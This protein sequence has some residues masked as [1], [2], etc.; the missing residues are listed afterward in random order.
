MTTSKTK[1]KSSVRPAKT[2]SVRLPSRLS[3]LIDLALKDLTAVENLPKRYRVDM[4][5][6]FVSSPDE[7]GV[8]EVCFAGAV[9]AR[10]CGADG[11]EGKTRKLLDFGK[12]SNKFWALDYVRSGSI[13][14]AVRVLH[15]G[16]DDSLYVKEG[17]VKASFG[18][19]YDSR[20]SVSV[21]SFSPSLFKSQMFG[22][23]ARLRAIGL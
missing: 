1:K 7:F 10:R 21:Y 15:T 2:K 14:N 18:N 5:D 3:D 11:D 9:M 17:K 4:D 6:N 12:N 23:A 8:C 13:G 16:T 22:I 20:E 19:E